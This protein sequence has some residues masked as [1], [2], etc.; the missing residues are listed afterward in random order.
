MDE[1]LCISSIV[2]SYPQCKLCVQQRS[3]TGLSVKCGG[4]WFVR[5]K[6]RFVGAGWIA[7]WTT[8]SDQM[9]YND[10]IRITASAY[11][12]ETKRFTDGRKPTAAHISR[13]SSFPDYSCG[14][15]DRAHEPA[16]RIPGND[17]CAPYG[18]AHAPWCSGQ[19]AEA[20]KAA[21]CSGLSND[22]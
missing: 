12:I 16:T 15:T 9:Q 4:Y 20:K 22:A 17:S 18:K 6:K 21:C 1:M 8:R 10:S 7:N 13:H 5:R 14:T 19:D 3:W 11:T 2:A